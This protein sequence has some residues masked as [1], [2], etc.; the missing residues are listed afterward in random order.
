MR[1]PDK[2]KSDTIFSRN[3][4]VAANWRLI[5]FSE[6]TLVTSEPK[7]RP[8]YSDVANG[9]GRYSSRPSRE[10]VDRR[11]ELRTLVGH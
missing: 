3:E 4:N 8:D 2:E 10:Q 5:T 6:R 7:V 1:V 11:D 9:N